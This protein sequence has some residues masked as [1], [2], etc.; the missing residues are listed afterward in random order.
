M[1]IS[2]NLPATAPN[3]NPS[4]N[5]DGRNNLMAA[6]RSTGGFGSLKKSGTL[7]AAAINQPE[8][9]PVRSFSQSNPSK[10]DMTSS[11]AAALQQR[12]TALQSDG[13]DDSDDDD[14]K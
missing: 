1:T 8:S 5:A 14:W 11:L 12:K 7:K 2:S 13:S 10:N 4:P 3:I 9:A 6:I